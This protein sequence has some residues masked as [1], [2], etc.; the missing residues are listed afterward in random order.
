MTHETNHARHR[1]AIPAVALAALL[2]AGC[3]SGHVGEDWQCPL[4]AGG[5]CASVA[6]ADPAVPDPG[7]AGN[8]VL[9]EPLYRVRDGA[10]GAGAPSG[11]PL[12][13]AECG[14]GLDPFGWL[15]R[16][17]GAEDGGGTRPGEAP[18][19]VARMGA[20]DSPNPAVSGP[21]D[22]Q[23]GPG[24][25]ASSP[26]PGPS[27][28]GAEEMSAGSLRVETSSTGHDA[29]GDDLR[30][31]EIVARIWIAPFVDGHGVYRE[32]SHVR[33]VLEPAGWRLK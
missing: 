17:F 5:A 26:A 32:A 8:A 1:S 9:A 7:K 20:G 12:C 2:L 23:P 33:V 4:A 3:S 13:A 11:K 16:L 30:S 6:A 18:E 24:A 29:G 21:N 14:A 15:A 25:S 10:G 31:G 19:T 22:V 27:K 28:P